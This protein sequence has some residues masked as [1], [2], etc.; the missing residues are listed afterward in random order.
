[1]AARPD[2]YEALATALAPSVWELDDVK[3]GVLLQLFG[4]THK[5]LDEE[6]TGG[7]KRRGE[8]N[9]LLMGDPGASKSQLLPLLALARPGSPLLALAHPCSP[10]LALRRYVQVAAAAVRAQSGTA[11]HLHLGQGPLRC[12]ADGG[13]ASHPCS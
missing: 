6:S 12:R 9:V 13:A 5:K 11:G 10:F 7:S 8:I 3:R 4:G 1:M 2:L